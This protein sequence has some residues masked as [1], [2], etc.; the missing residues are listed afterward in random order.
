MSETTTP[1]VKFGGDYHT[2]QIYSMGYEFAFMSQKSAEDPY[3]QATPFV[4]CKDFLH[5]AVW[6]FLNK[7]S[8]NIYGFKY[9]HAK[10]PPLV[11][12]RTVL[13]FRNTQFKKKPKDFHGKREACLEFLQKID[14]MLGFRPTEI[15]EVENPDGPTWLII[16]DKGWQHAPTMISLFTLL[17]RVG[18]YHTPGAEVS[19]TLDAAEK[20]KIK[21]GGSTG[22]AGNRD[23]NYVKSSRKGIEVILK[24]GLDVFYKK[25]KDNYPE[26]LR[27]NGL[28]DN[29]GIVNFTA[30]RPKKVIPHWYRSSI[31]GE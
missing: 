26:S 24:H 31:W 16:A 4:Y 19:E 17:V 6:A 9:D 11:T 1:E 29:Y 13:A 5:D 14:R 22:Y 3:E 7:T 10:N 12:K 8:V 23:G 18:C 2:A 27:K 20:G 25:Q 21:I 30:G 28:H 15:H